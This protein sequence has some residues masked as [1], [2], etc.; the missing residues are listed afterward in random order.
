M[1]KNEEQLDEVM[2][3]EKVCNMMLDSRVIKSK[4]KRNKVFVAM[5]DYYAGLKEEMENNTVN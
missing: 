2:L 5:R 1:D 4:A 3:E